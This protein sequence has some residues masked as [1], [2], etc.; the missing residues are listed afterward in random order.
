[1]S[2][3][4][5]LLAVLAHPDDESLGNGGM[6]ARY[7][8]EGVETYLVTATRG[9]QG[10]FGPPDENPGPDE[11][12]KIRE[13]ELHEAAAVLG[14]REVSFLDYRDG[15]LDRADHA[16]AVARIADHIRRIKPHVVVTFDPVGL[17]GHPDHIAICRFTTSAVALASDPTFESESRLP[18]HS[19]AKLYYMAW[20]DDDVS[21]YEEI[22]GTLRME[23]DGMTR[24]STPWPA[25]AV[26][27]R[28]DTAAYWQRAWEAVSRHKSQLPG[29]ARLLDLPPERH[30]ALWGR[31]FYYLVFGPTSVVSGQ[32]DDLFSGLENRFARAEPPTP[33][34][35]AAECT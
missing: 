32:E 27:T 26:T 14:I 12:G 13:R 23:I 5:R 33:R 9:E 17:Y 22:F 20:T 25:W 28:I 34:P 3:A 4:K 11:L 10:W 31:L 6:L 35:V 8:A 7:A 24:S 18:P 15:E 16:E 29:Y 2:N 30:L 21:G 1:M 19:V